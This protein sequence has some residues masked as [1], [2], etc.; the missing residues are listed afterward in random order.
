[1]IPA[2]KEKRTKRKLPKEDEIKWTNRCYGYVRVSTKQQTDE[3]LSLENQ[4]KKINAW[5]V[6]SDHEVVKIYEDKGVTGTS[7]DARK[8]LKALL[9]TIKHG[10]TL[11]TLAF[12]RLSRS[13]RDFLN[14]VHDLGMRGCRIVIINEGLDTKTPYGRFAATMFSAVAE[15]EADIISHRVTDAMKLKKEKGEFVG[16]IP[17]GWKLSDGPGSDLIEHP[18]EQQV[19][20]KIKEWRNS[21]N[22]EGRQYSYDAIADILTRE[23]IKPPGKSKKWTQSTVN[24]IY[25]RGEVITK[26]RPPERQKKSGLA[27]ELKERKTY[28]SDEE[29]EVLEKPPGF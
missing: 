5:A 17:Y 1:M 26:G 20:A 10:E 21:I 2:K 9:L 25:N 18:E 22:V 16:R 24:R 29:A 8:D 12:S 3:G 14:I 28:S 23:G 7:I 15:L 13:A 4:R 11:V 19:I 6:M 27:K